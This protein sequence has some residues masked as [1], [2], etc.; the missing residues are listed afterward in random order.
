M[1]AAYSTVLAV[2]VEGI[3]SNRRLLRLGAQQ[4]FWIQYSVHLKILL[5]SSVLTRLSR[6]YCGFGDYGVTRI[7][8]FLSNGGCATKRPIQVL[9]GGARGSR[10]PGRAG[11][12]STTVREHESCPCVR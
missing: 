7:V 6:L 2:A 10:W 5:Y 4:V 1:H 11:S 9:K 3:Q 8:E 12:L